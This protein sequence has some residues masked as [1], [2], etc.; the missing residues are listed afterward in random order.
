ME[1]C[2][3]PAILVK[4]GKRVEFR[5]FLAN[6]HEYPVMRIVTNFHEYPENDQAKGRRNLRHTVT[7]APGRGG[8][9]GRMLR[10]HFPPHLAPFTSQTMGNDAS[11]L[12]SSHAKV[13]I[14]LTLPLHCD[15]GENVYVVGNVAELGCWNPAHA[16][17]LYYRDN[18]GPDDFWK[19]AFEVPASHGFI[20][21]KY[22][23]KREDKVRWEGGTN[24]LLEWATRPSI[25]DPVTG[26]ERAPEWFIQVQERFDDDGYGKFDVCTPC[27]RKE[28]LG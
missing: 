14:E 22:I 4:V 9:N 19:I 18:I 24:R 6:V 3:Q 2:L 7:R 1:L 27:V 17:R 26:H 10:H 20:E 28:W 8:R 16:R 5:H 11:T 13:L 25:V 21:Y 23:I 12:R 15:F